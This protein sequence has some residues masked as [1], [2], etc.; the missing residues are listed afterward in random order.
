LFSAYIDSSGKYWHCS[1][2]EGMPMAYGIDVT[3]VT[4]FQKEVWLSEPMTKWRNRLFE[5]NR[6]CPL[7]KE[8]HI[9]PELATGE[10]PDKPWAV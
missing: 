2:G 1:F 10:F 9:S 7:Y 3:K 8:I 5:L 4:D 6:E